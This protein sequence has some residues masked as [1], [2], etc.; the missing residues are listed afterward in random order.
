MASYAHQDG[1]PI[2]VEEVQQNSGFT[3]ISCG[4]SVHYRSGT[5]RSGY[6]E[7]RAC[8]VHD[9]SSPECELYIGGHE[10]PPGYIKRKPIKPRFQYDVNNKKIKIQSQTID[11]V[12]RKI[13]LKKK[14]DFFNL[15]MIINISITAESADYYS[16][17][18]IEIVSNA[19]TREVRIDDIRNLSAAIPAF[20]IDSD[21]GKDNI[22]VENTPPFI[23]RAF[24]SKIINLQSRDMW[25]LKDPLGT[26]LLFES[27]RISLNYGETY[28]ILIN[29]N[30]DTSQF[31][32][33]FL[34]PEKFDDPKFM[35]FTFDISSE[36]AGKSSFEDLSN[37]ELLGKYL[38]EYQIS[39]NT[40]PKISLIKPTPIRIE[41]GTIYIDPYS[42]RCK[43]KLAN[44][45][46][47]EEFDINIISTDPENEGTHAYEENGKF[48]DIDL[49][50][51][52]EVCITSHDETTT[53]YRVIKEN[54]KPNTYLGI[55]IL[56]NEKSY[57]L[58]D[59]NLKNHLK[60][61][62]SYYFSDSIVNSC[63]DIIHNNEE[64]KIP[65]S[66]DGKEIDGG[67]FGN[68]Q[69]IDPKVRLKPSNN[70]FNPAQKN[71]LQWLR[72]NA[73]IINKD[74]NL[75]AIEKKIIEE[76]GEH[77]EFENHINYLK[78]E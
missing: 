47:I 24:E 71:I 22:Q 58:L 8:F 67:N 29:K 74:I 37:Q 38:K 53:Y 73:G 20:D 25:I 6:I 55:N 50:N 31:K 27:L 66:Y 21:F 5:I 72:I 78:G 12:G 1:H 51:A 32:D 13:F 44:K 61:E 76:Y 63:L 60:P 16:D 68:Y 59:Q 46:D 30:I 11:M 26:G 48:I 49:S 45:E 54:P 3:C 15:S 17:G 2:E 19:G 69:F 10:V 41:K 4:E 57:N 62:T 33:N 65:F 40:T 28:A 64:N 9:E 52:K 18:K 36:N 70:Q 34:Q 75:D 42:T 35:L 7:V 23:N 77:S 56:I 14:R 39:W 43:F